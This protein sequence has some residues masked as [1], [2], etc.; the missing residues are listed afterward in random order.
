MF[1]DSFVNLGFGMRVSRKK[2]ARDILVQWHP[3]RSEFR[4]TL[5]IRPGMVSGRL[6]L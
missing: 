1:K 5:R 6:F 2:K 4:Q 3:F